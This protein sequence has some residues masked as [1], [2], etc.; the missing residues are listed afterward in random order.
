M[1]DRDEWLALTTEE[2][3]EPGLAICDPHHHFWEHPGSRYLLE[4]FRQDLMGGHN[5]VGTV[6]VECQQKYYED[7]PAA[8]RSVGETRYVAELTKQASDGIARGIV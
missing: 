2:A 5:V 7:G 3:L 1:S 4:E 6:F 8:L